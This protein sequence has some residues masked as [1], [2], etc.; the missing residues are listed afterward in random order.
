M[1]PWQ[2][3]W[4]ASQA[5]RGP[6]G[7]DSQGAGPR[8]REDR[9]VGS[10]PAP[11]GKDPLPAPHP[12]QGLDSGWAVQGKAPCQRSHRQAPGS[13]ATDVSE[14]EV[15]NPSCSPFATSMAFLDVVGLLPLL[16]S[17]QTCP[18]A[19]RPLLRLDLR[20]LIES[21]WYCKVAPGL[22][23]SGTV[24][25]TERGNAPAQSWGLSGSCCIRK[26]SLLRRRLMD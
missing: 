6:A 7:G 15:R 4:T 17:A 19:P 10:Q 11:L 8:G 16:F 26:H 23:L 5:T 9:R 21:V 3:L 13:S 14:G 12:Q 2:T 22:I 20:W 18:R 25:S 1:V 24:C